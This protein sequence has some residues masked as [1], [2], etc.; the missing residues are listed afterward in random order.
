NLYAKLVAKL[1]IN[2]RTALKTNIMIITNLDLKE[3][4]IE[5]KALQQALQ[6]NAIKY[7]FVYTIDTL[8]PY[9]KYILEKT[10][11]INEDPNT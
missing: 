9:K 2:I 1:L 8:I 10:D 4:L 3:L 11:T 5:T 7:N 6:T